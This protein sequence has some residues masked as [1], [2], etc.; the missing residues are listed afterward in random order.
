MRHQANLPDIL[1]A[2]AALAAWAWIAGAP[3]AGGEPGL[4]NPSFE[5]GADAGGVP[6]GWRAGRV[7]LRW[8]TLTVAADAAGKR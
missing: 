8:S 2:A 7:S 3:A 1:R 4:I 5:D 6:R